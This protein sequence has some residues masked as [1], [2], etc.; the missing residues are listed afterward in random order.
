QSSLE[1][2]KIESLLELESR[3]AVMSGRE[4]GFD[5]R[6]FNFASNVAV[7]RAITQQNGVIAG[8]YGSLFRTETIPRD[9]NPTG[10]L[11][12]SRKFATGAVAIKPVK[13]LAG[14]YEINGTVRECRRFCG[15]IDAR[16]IRV[17][18]QQLLAGGAHL[19]VWLDSKNSISVSEK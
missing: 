3:D 16:K 1:A 14:S 13:C 6:I 11:Q 12:D 10:G 17:L 4:K 8:N 19:S 7:V 15:R 9:H 5:V 18:R 2:F